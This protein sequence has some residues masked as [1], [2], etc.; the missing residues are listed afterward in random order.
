[1]NREEA[2]EAR[3]AVVVGTGLTVVLFGFTYL[4]SALIVH[5]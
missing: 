1:M 4:F 2:R 5:L 3:E